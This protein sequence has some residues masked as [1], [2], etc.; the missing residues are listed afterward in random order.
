MNTA[1]GE[2]YRLMLD[3][4]FKSVMQG[5]AM[6]RGDLPG[7]NRPDCFVIDDWR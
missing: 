5:V 4:G 2:A 1:R 3:Q 7:F 6:Q